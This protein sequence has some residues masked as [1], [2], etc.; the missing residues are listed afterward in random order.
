MSDTDDN[1][2]PAGA[3]A[4]AS[5]PGVA[6]GGV[7]ALVGTATA[8]VLGFVLTV[9]V[10]RGLSATMAGEFFTVTALF[11]IVQTVV[12]FGVAAGV[13]RFVP[14]FLVL[15]RASDIPALLAMY[16]EGELKLDELITNRYRLDDVNQGYQDLRDGKNIRGVIDFT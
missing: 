15:G 7:L 4:P 13:V 10:T 14:R 6:R 12:A 11:L 5:L 2:P 16:R 3:G 9:V 8:A 1:V